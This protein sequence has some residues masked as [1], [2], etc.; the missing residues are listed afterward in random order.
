MRKLFILVLALFSFT[1]ANAQFLRFGVKGGVSSTN[2][3][4]DETSLQGLTTTDGLKQFAVEQG[5][6]S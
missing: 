1:I 5:T 6:P 4:I 3:K 2:V